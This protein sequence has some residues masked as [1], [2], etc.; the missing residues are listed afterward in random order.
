MVPTI[1]H[2]RITQIE[3]DNLERLVAESFLSGSKD[4]LLFELEEKVQRMKG[5]AYVMGYQAGYKSG[6]RRAERREE[7]DGE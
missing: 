5:K 7:D 4:Y 1:K 2:N 3:W 6:E